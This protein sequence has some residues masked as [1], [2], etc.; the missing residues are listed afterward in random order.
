MRIRSP[1]GRCLRTPSGTEVSSGKW[2]SLGAA[3][4]PGLS[5]S[6]WRR[7]LRGSEAGARS[8]LY[9]YYYFFFFFFFFFVP[10]A[11]PPIIRSH[12][13]RCLV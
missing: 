2:A 1:R 9:Y 3:G 11:R 6:V 7:Q 4:S 13:R 5:W 10:H 12:I 8:S